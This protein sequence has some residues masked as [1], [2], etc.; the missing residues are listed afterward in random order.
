MQHQGLFHS[1]TKK[2]SINI[3]TAERKILLVFVYYISLGA[4]ALTAF[5]LAIKHLNYNIT[6]TFNYFD[7]QKSGFNNTCEF[8]I[9]QFPTITVAAYV[10]LG[11]QPSINLVYALNI[12]EIKYALK[13]VYSQ[14][15]NRV[16]RS[17][18]EGKSE[19]TAIQAEL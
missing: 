11:L 3:G 1:K 10:L 16:L 13:G 9:K 18:T 17:T 2:T 14:V 19:T 7:C 8:N 6:E 15:R 5:T 12:K 4:V